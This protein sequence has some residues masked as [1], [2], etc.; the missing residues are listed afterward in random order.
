MDSFQLEK[1]RWGDDDFGQMGWHDA[2]I[3]SFHASPDQ[4]EFLLD[5][6]Y[7]FKWVKP[8]KDES[9]F[10]FWVAPVT[11][12]FSNAHSVV[13]D[14]ESP[15]GNIEIA[16][17]HRGEPEATPNQ[18]TTQQSYRFE[19][20]EGAISLVAT[21]FELFVR[22]APELLGVQTLGLSQRGGISFERKLK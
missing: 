3:W 1:D 12:V 21:G 17:L 6:D 15:Q 10:K 22:A 5:L 19:C 13:I 4:F 8:Q 2:T 7:I 16:D 11:M 18:K 20:Q 14:I 9:F